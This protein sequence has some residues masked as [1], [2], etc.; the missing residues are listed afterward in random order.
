RAAV[1][2]TNRKRLIVAGLLTEACVTFPVLSALQDGFEVFV[3]ADA[4]GGLTPLGHDMALRRIESAGAQMTS[5]LQ[6]CWNF[7]ATG[8]GTIPMTVRGQSSNRTAAA[9]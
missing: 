9:M 2:A 6:Y 3:V 7:N 8:R 5:W 4:C 1:L